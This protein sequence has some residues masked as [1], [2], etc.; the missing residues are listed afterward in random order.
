MKLV[1][2]I[3]LFIFSFCA[4]A[5][6]ELGDVLFY[7]TFEQAAFSGSDPIQIMLA[8]NPGVDST[9]Y[10]QYMA[11]FQ[12]HLT[13]LKKKTGDN[14][15]VRT[16]E[17]VFYFNHRR[18]LSWYNSNVILSDLFESGKYDCLT[19]TAFYAATLEALE[20]PYDIYEFNYHVFLVAHCQDGDVL[21]EPTDPLEGYVTN[22][23]EIESRIEEF[24]KNEGM[25]AG[26]DGVANII[27]LNDLAGLQYYNMGIDSYNR[28][29]YAHAFNYIQKANFLYPSSRIKE[30]QRVFKNQVR[31]VSS[32]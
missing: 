30:I 19:G 18:K 1:L 14:L 16:L 17:T 21:I 23:E 32:N 8:A 25:S 15:S 31:L 4:F 10:S 13:K 20:I 2:N 26:M 5:Q 28:R 6:E 9:K 7:S 3:S 22:S 24:S 27:T 12:E 29:D 11:D